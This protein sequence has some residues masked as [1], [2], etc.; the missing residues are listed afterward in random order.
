MNKTKKSKIFLTKYKI[1][2]LKNCLLIV[3]WYYSGRSL[4]EVSVAVRGVDRR[5]W[6]LFARR[7]RSLFD[8]RRSVVLDGLQG[9]ER[10]TERKHTA[11]KI[12]QHCCKIQINVLVSRKA[13]MFFKT[14]NPNL[15]QQLFSCQI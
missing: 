5:R 13:L 15:S 1:F 6:P 14:S 10:W 3:R 4:F 8:C 2:L 11:V 12:V 7:R 9:H